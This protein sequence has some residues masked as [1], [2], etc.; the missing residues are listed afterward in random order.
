MIWD[1]WQHTLE[2][3]REKLNAVLKKQWQEWEIPRC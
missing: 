2:S 3:L 1:K